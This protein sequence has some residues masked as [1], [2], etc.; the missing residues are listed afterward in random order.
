MA[1]E[2]E[3]GFS[4]RQPMWHGLGDV[5][6]EH[7][8]DYR[9][10]LR[11]AG[12]D[13]TVDESP[14]MIQ[15]P[16]DPA[17][18]AE[19]IMGAVLAG[20]NYAET[21]D[22]VAALLTPGLLNI[23][24][25]DGYKTTFRTDCMRPLGV[26]GSKYPLVQ[27]EEVFA[28]ADA[29]CGDGDEGVLFE[30]GG[31]LREG[32]LV[33]VLVKLDGQKFALPGTDDLNIPYVLVSTGHDGGTPFRAHLTHVRVVCAN[34]WNSATESAPAEYVVRHVGDPL[35]RIEEAREALGLAVNWSVEFEQIARALAAQPMSGAEWSAFRDVL[36]PFPEAAASDRVVR[37]A[38]ERRSQLDELFEIQG[39][40]PDSGGEFKPI[41]HTRWAALNAATEWYDWVRPVH[42]VTVEGMPRQTSEERRFR[43]SMMSEARFKD[44]A[45][46]L[47][48]AED[49]VATAAERM[50]ARGTR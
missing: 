32:R 33:W 8:E 1:H 49:V 15:G 6:P 41:A 50:E 31:V 39:D 36:L 17:V 19:T 38:I 25:V 13:W 43:R 29:L 26:V 7:P 34:T 16:F 20:A 12:A 30:T 28:F 37:N 45:L 22:R 35:A 4:V 3:T 48:V 10:A 24:R 47:L 23:E 2:F 42:C 27:N 21:R 11:K 46:G 9:D 40:R 14:C 18:A 44:E 5:L